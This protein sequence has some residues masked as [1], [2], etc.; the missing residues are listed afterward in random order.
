[1]LTKQT[2]QLFY[3]KYQYKAV[4]V[5]PAANWFRG[6][7]VQGA[8]EKLM[9]FTFDAKASFSNKIKTK[10][11]LE[12]CL[13]LANVL[14]TLV[15]FEIR[16]ESPFISFYTNSKVDI[17][18]LIKVDK[19]RI[20]YISI[21]ADNSTLESNTVILPKVDYDFRVTIGR[22]RS[23]HDTFIEWAEKNDKLKLTKS[24]KSALKKPVSWGGTYFYVKGEKNLLVAKMMLGGSINKV[25]RILKQ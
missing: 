14:A 6:S 23:A 17:D 4:L 9:E 11:D 19:D 24:C 12:Y 8:L 21:P 1:M 16:V 18:K 3:R 25:E 5:C 2:R 20:K 13:K 22:T 15:N 7:N 10:E